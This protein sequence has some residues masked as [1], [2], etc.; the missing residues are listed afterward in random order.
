MLPGFTTLHRMLFWELARVFSL[1]LVALTG[2]FVVAGLVQ[3]A[4]QLGLSA[5]QIFQIIPLFIPSILPYTIPAT[6]LFASCVVYGRL[7]NDNEAVAIKA[8]GIDLYSMLKPA[9]LLGVLT[10]LVTAGIGYAIIPRTQVMMHEEIMRDPEEVLYNMLKRDR[11]LRIPGAKYVLYVRDVQG[12]RLIDVVVKRKINPDAMD[13]D[14][15]ARTREARLKVDLE[16]RVF[17]VDADAWNV[18]DR[19]TVVHSEGT[20]PIDIELPDIFSTRQIKSRPMALEWEELA[21]RVNELKEERAKVLERRENNRKFAESQT[22]P[23]LRKK[24]ASEDEHHANALRD[25]DRNI[26]NVEYE[27]HI[28]PALAVGCLVFALIGCPAGIWANRSDYLSTFVICFLPTIALYYPLLLSGRGLAIDG[29]IPMILGVW[30]ANIVVGL[31]AL[32]QTYRLVKR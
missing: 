15:I 22:D 13:Y 6:T 9:L 30:G 18:K 32:I 19:E 25:A 16:R 27:Y 28:R 7:S 4:S 17:T 5:N 23:L 10:M 20:A 14:Y 11:N 31:L 8:A 3:Q 12:R 24:Y 1:C 21:G 29:K 2:L 26:R